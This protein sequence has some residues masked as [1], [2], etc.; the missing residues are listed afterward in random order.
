MRRSVAKFDF[1]MSWIQKLGL[2]LVKEAG[3][4]T[5]RSPSQVISTRIGQHGK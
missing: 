3:E 2:H 4:A 5:K 1:R